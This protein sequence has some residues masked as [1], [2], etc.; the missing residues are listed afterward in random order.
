MTESTI[1]MQWHRDRRGFEITESPIYVDGE[2]FLKGRRIVRKG[3][4]LINTEPLKNDRIFVTFAA[5]RD[6]HEL[7]HFVET[8]GPLTLGGL[9]YD[10]DEIQV[11]MFGIMAQTPQAQPE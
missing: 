8:H 5:V 6:A 1:E 11:R 3:G 4:E 2:P 9:R 7:L 10:N